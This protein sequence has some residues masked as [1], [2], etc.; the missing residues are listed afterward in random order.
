MPAAPPRILIVEDEVIVSTEIAMCLR[1]LGYE[2]A[3]SARDAASAR[4][5]LGFR[6]PDLVLLDI[7]LLNGDSGLD[8]ARHLLQDWQIPFVFLTAY[9]DRATL[10]AAKELLP[11]GYVVKPFNE[12]DLA[13]AVELALHR[14]N[15]QNRQGL[16]ALDRLNR[17]LVH[18]LTAREYEVLGL[19][20]EGLTY[21]EV[22]QR[23]FIGL[24]TVKSY[25]KT[26]FSKLHVGSRHELIHWVQRAG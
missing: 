13:A 10:Q 9:A 11:Y 15:S 22:G 21:R 2:V 6:R 7:H 18:G 1:K 8:V 19:L 25:Q 24:N 23:L 5:M 20:Y 16:P 17:N 12:N 26:L 3:G 14:F 4:R